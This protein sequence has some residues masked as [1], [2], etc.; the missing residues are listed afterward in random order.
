MKIALCEDESIYIN[1]LLNAIDAWTKNNNYQDIFTYTYMQAEELLEDWEKGEFFDALFLD[2]EFAYMS[3]FELARKIRVTDENVPIYFVTNSDRYMQ[4]GYEVG[5]YR[6]LKKPINHAA[7]AQCLDHAFLQCQMMQS[8]T[9]II[10]PR[11]Y[12]ARIKYKDVLYID[13][14]IHAVEIHT[15]QGDAYKVPIKT[16]FESYAQALPQ[17]HFVRCHRGYIVNIMHVRKY[18]QDEIYL[19]GNVII[20]LGRHYRKEAFVRLDEYFRK[21]IH[22]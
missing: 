5:A 4:A 16:S 19:N 7:I 11:G 22:F 9:F 17:E 6:Y 3:G 14:L 20:T 10:S 18:T 1:A 12:T 2:I 8:D 21:A 15:T 13:S